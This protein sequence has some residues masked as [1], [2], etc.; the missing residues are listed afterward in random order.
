[1]ATEMKLHSNWHCPPGVRS[2]PEKSY[3]AHAFVH[4]CAQ[5]SMQCDIYALLQCRDIYALLQ[6]RLCLWA[7]LLD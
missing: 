6:C 3:L 1:M 4:V 2:F 7:Q 5:I